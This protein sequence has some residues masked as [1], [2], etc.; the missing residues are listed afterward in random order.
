MIAPAIPAD[1]AMRIAALEQLKVLDKPLEERFERI[2]RLLCRL[3][4]VPTAVISMVDETRQWF[5]SAQGTALV[6]TA[7][8]ISFCGHAILTDEIMVVPDAKNDPRFSDNPLVTGPEQIAFYAGHPLH[9]PDGSRIGVLCAM[10][11]KPRTFTADDLEIL[12]DLAELAESELR[13]TAIVSTQVDLLKQ[14]DAEHRRALTDPLTRLWNRDGIMEILARE[15]SR[16]L[17]ADE[18]LAVL[19]ADIDHFKRVNDTYGHPVG[20]VVIKEVA[21]NILTSFRD[22]DAVGRIGGEEF[23]IILPFNVSKGNVQTIANRV[24]TRI[25]EKPII[26]TAGPLSITLSIGGIEDVIDNATTAADM[27]RRADEALYRAK[28]A[29]RNRTELV[30]CA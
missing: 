19:I 7:R 27:V 3:L 20:D 11:H 5:K 22:V 6:E 1:E 12:H 24:C 2:T 26:T 17:L 10:D 28:Q 30:L 8:N 29:G 14:L 13:S 25:A 16:A 23:L 15:L 9:A 4:G 18:H 21:K